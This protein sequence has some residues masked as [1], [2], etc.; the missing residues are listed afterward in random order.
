MVFKLTKYCK[1]VVPTQDTYLAMSNAWQETSLIIL[2]YYSTITRLSLVSHIVDLDPTIH[3]LK[4]ERAPL[5]SGF[6][7]IFSHAFRPGTDPYI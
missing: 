4:Q 1:Y 2:K 7:R 5:L 6:P 3:H